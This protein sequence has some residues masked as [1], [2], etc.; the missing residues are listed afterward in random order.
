MSSNPRRSFDAG[1][2]VLTPR[3][4]PLGRDASHNVAFATEQHAYCVDSRGVRVGD[5]FAGLA[6]VAL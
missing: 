1:V 2:L 6:P 3:A 4:D 5:Y